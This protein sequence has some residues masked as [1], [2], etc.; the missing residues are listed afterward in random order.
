MIVCIR[1]L[2]L[3]FSEAFGHRWSSSFNISSNTNRTTCNFF[4]SGVAQRKNSKSSNNR[5]HAASS[6]STR[7]LNTSSV[8]TEGHK[9]IVVGGG[10]AGTEAACAA[11][12]TGVPTLLITHKKNTIGNSPPANRI[13]LMQHS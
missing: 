5:M 3:N 11:A 8:K 9:V 2:R 7:Q 12:R 10:H 6:I 1:F 4:C 13:I